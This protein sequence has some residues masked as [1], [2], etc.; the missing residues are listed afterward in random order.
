MKNKL[1][2]IL[3]AMFLVLVQII[4]MP[5]TIYAIDT[6]I[7]EIVD[8][9]TIETPVTATVSKVSSGT[10][11]VSI[12]ESMDAGVLSNEKDN[13]IEYSISVNFYE[14]ESS[15][16]SLTSSSVLISSDK[17]GELTLSGNDS[18]VLPF[19]NNLDDIKVSDSQTIASNILIESQDVKKAEPGSYSG[20]VSFNFEFIE[21]QTDDEQTTEATT[22]QTTTKEDTTGSTSGTTT[23]VTTTTTEPASTTTT[24]ATTSSPSTTT[25]TQ[26]SSSETT[27]TTTNPSSTATTTTQVTTESTTQVTTESTTVTTTQ[28]TTEPSTGLQNGDYTAD[29]SMMK[30]YDITD[31]S[32]CDK[33]FSNSADITISGDYATIILYVI[34]PIPNFSSYGTPISDVWFEYEG[35]TYSATVTTGGEDRYFD[36]DGGFISDEGYYPTAIVKVIVPKQAVLDSEDGDLVCSAYVDAVMM[37]RQEFF[38]IL[39]L[40]DVDLDTDGDADDTTTTVPSTTE[41]STTAPS[42][43]TTTNATT[44]TTN[45]TTTTQK[46]TTTTQTTTSASSSTGLTDGAYTADVSMMKYYDITDYSMCDK[47]FYNFAD[48]VVNGDNATLTLYVIDPIPN[49]S[50]YGT[51]VS[52]VWFEYNGNT[53][54]ATITTGGGDKYFDADGAFISTDGEYST[55]KITVTLPKEAVLDAANGGLVCSPYVA[56]VMM[57]RE[58]FYV[59]LDVEGVEDDDDSST[60]TTTASTTTSS[61]TT[62]SNATTATSTTNSTTNSTTSSSST[63]TST[64]TSSGS[65]SSGSSSSVTSLS[66]GTYTADVSMM[67]YVDITDY[68]MC[69]KLFYNSADI[70]VSGDKATLTLYVIDPIPNFSSYGTPVS[71][72]WFEYNGN[73]YNATVTSGGGDK[74]FDADGAFISTD[75][76]YSTSKIT[77]TLPKQAILD[78]ANGGL[79]CSP[80][81]D[82]VMM[83][84]EQFYVILDV[85][86]V[87]SSGSSSSNSSSS[88]SSSSNNSSSSSDSST[89]TGNDNADEVLIENGYFTAAVEMRKVASINDLSMCSPLF[90]ERVDIYIE[91]DMATIT[92]YLINPIPSYP[93]YGTPLLDI[94]FTYDGVDYEGVLDESVVYTRYFNYAAGFIEEA[95]YYDSSPITVNIPVDALYNTTEGELT[96]TGYVNV[97]MNSTQSFFVFLTDFM[98][99]TTG[100]EDPTVNENS[101]S[102]DTNNDSTDSE[103]VEDALSSNLSSNTVKTLYA[104]SKAL[105]FVIA[106]TILAVAALGGYFAYIYYRRKK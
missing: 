9:Q 77:V 19:T 32:M 20:T 58:Q 70:V 56:A 103:D 33:L 17:T 38:V 45:A 92:L 94:I 31:Y 25:T 8:S 26:P 2:K 95:G 79:I 28:P 22:S 10:Y 85:D 78:A 40:D 102:S 13:V 72:V 84:R 16:Y 37:S 96:C 100:G 3:I 63:T 64:T 52:D 74:Y 39:Q 73:T 23:E 36:A 62:T 83:S 55:S 12:P 27:T 50:S 101:S 80:Y 18:E 98:E 66:N 88:G 15:N 34:D 29:V 47:L 42:T 68:S 75:G 44:T 106:L 71:D 4:S 90:H 105:G 53:Y 104:Q 76:E 82:A 86:G 21:V 99:G 6:T 57:S 91:D 59:I 35:V 81:V 51:P 1:K 60:S 48:I 65:S 87:S 97:I 93:D 24:E 43:A 5:M 89:V 67:K 54:D 49:F 14:S 69:D 11:T 61:T 41:S 46:S 30:Y 7:S